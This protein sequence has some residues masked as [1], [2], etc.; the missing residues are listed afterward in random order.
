MSRR[1]MAQGNG[2]IFSSYIVYYSHY[3]SSKT[4]IIS[5]FQSI[6]RNNSLFL[7][8]IFR[9]NEEYQV[10][11]PNEKIAIQAMSISICDAPYRAM[12]RVA[13]ALHKTSV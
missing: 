6:F 12:M 4:K 7:Q 13:N 3:F 1:L 2:L 5:L 11:I 9:N 10:Y 8:S